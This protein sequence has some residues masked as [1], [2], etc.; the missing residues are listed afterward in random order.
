MS[1]E[2][3]I[4]TNI[5]TRPNGSTIAYQSVEG[6]GIGL[7]FLHGLHSDKSGT[8]SHHLMEYCRKVG[9]PFLALDMYGHGDSSGNFEDGTISQWTE[10]VIDVMDQVCPQPQILIGSSMGGWVM[11]RVAQQHP[12]RVAGLIGI[13]AAPDFTED[14]MWAKMSAA[15]RKEL[16]RS[17]FIASPSEYGDEP[18][19]ISLGLI[20][21]GR[22]NLVLRSPLEIDRPVHL[23]H[24]QQDSDV[25]WQ[26]ALRLQ[27]NLT[28]SRVLVTLLADGDHRLSRGTDLDLLERVA[29]HMI[30]MCNANS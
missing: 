18:Y 23:I 22:K 25:P 27:D 9:H 29:D 6:T 1:S 19:R 13:A 30:Q 4:Q 2:I 5:L 7:V 3:A 8:K 11:L 15:E 21:D 28:S 12:D 10:D 26:T 16:T 17:G 14:L 24:G 20:E